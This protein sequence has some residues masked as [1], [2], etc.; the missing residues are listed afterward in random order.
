MMRT[1]QWLLCHEVAGLLG[2]T[3][4]TVHRWV[5]TGALP[6][7]SRTG[8]NGYGYWKLQDV[9]VARV[10]APSYSIGKPRKGRTHA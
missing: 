4:G 1:E 6:A 8:R 9:E 5:K 10:T 7:P 3:R 2:I